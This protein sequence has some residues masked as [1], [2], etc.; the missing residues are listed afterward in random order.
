MAWRNDFHFYSRTCD[1]C[2]K[3]IVSLYAPDEPAIV[4]CG[5][6]WWSDAWDPTAYNQEFDFSRP[7]FEQ[8]VELQKKVPV[9]ALIN[10][11]GIGSVNCAYT[12]D[13][14]FGRCGRLTFKFASRELP[15]A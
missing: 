4:Y 13:F 2:K 10:D 7:F 6:C 8:F 3:S 15:V 12:N 9:L 11:D 1:L 5:K 14:A